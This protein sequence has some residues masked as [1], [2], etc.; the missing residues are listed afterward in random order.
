M[1]V[2]NGCDA[3]AFRFTA[4]S[5]TSDCNK[6]GQIAVSSITPRTIKLVAVCVR[7]SITGET[8]DPQ[9]H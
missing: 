3:T 4:K 2:A 9:L 6:I 5:I 7:V 8:D 1:A